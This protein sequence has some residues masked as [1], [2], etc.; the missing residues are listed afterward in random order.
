MGGL[1]KYMPITWITSLI[2]SLADVDGAIGTLLVIVGHRS[3]SPACA[4]PIVLPLGP[5]A[6]HPGRPGATHPGR[7][8]AGERS[9]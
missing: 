9:R 8:G 1:K 3:S 4:A 2:G 5:G 7:P 6:A